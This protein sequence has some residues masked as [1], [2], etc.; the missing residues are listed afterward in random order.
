MYYNQQAFISEQ[1]RKK[2]LLDEQKRQAMEEL[3]QREYARELDKQQKN[4]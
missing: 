4:K 1:S 2:Q 3:R